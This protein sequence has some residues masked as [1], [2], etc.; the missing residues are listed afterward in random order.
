M[1]KKV[2]RAILL[3]ACVVLLTSLTVTM[4]SLYG[5]FSEEQGIQLHQELSLPRS[6]RIPLPSLRSS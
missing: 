6:R 4:A 1:S 3:T 5:Y 2:F